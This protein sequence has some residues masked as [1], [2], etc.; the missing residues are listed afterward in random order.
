M[1]KNALAQVDSN[2]EIDGCQ[3]LE[4]EFVNLSKFKSWFTAPP[5]GYIEGKKIDRKVADKKEFKINWYRMKRITSKIRLMKISFDNVL[6]FKYPKFSGIFFKVIN[7]I[8]Y[9]I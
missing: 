9:K 4:F 8:F 3:V 7:F 1:D 5:R 2:I 6:N